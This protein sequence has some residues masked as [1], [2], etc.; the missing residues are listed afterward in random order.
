ME[1]R[2]SILKQRMFWL[3][4]LFG[5]ISAVL[6]KLGI[7]THLN[8]I[9]INILWSPLLPMLASM[10]WGWGYGLLAGI[11]G[12]D[13]P[14]L[15][16]SNNQWIN[17]STSLFFLEYFALV[18]C[19][20]NVQNLKNRIFWTSA[21]IACLSPTMFLFNGLFF[22][23]LSAVSPLLVKKQTVNNLSRKTGLN[24]VTKKE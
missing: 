8:E 9:D 2:F 18:G 14:F 7:E 22:N 16:W 6:S 12:G 23:R 19:V 11:S 20:H 15:L 17:P 3:S 5:I 13:S 1:L 4:I 21:K 10:A 24:F